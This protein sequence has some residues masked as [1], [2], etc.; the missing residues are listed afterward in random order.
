MIINYGLFLFETTE[1]K[2]CK[3]KIITDD[4]LVIVS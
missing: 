1:N 4:S 3:I 2:L